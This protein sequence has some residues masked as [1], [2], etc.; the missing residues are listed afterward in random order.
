MS[1]PSGKAVR[2][3][4]K[5]GA[6]APK[7]GVQTPVFFVF[8][9]MLP[10][11][12]GFVLFTAYP[13]VASLYQSFTRWDMVN[14]PRWIGLD[15]YKRMFFEDDLFWLSFKN[16]IWISATSIPIRIAFAM[17]TAFLLTKAGK[18][19]NIWR[20][21]FFLPSM[22]PVVAGTLIFAW[23]FQP[24]F[25]VLNLFLEKLGIVNMKHPLM[26]FDDPNMSKWA[27]I[28]MGLWGIGDTMIIFL[29]GLL[30][31]DKSLYESASLEG[32]NGFQQF[33]FITL[34]LMTPVIFFSAVTGI[35]GSF[36]YF[37][38]AYIATGLSIN[39]DYSKSMY[40][41]A[42]HIYETAFQQYDMGYAASLS[43]FLLFVTLICTVIML[44][45]QKRWVH[46][47]NGTMFK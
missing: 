37:T 43:W 14:A 39:N 40:F 15:N 41:Y 24:Y 12:S 34:P 46:Y 6:T 9:C 10:W 2:S 5:R 17:F 25:G 45:T 21:I 22:V 7:H 4:R 23:L 11:T 27:L 1:F 18:T 47:P 36:Q 26:W 31:I 3:P 44:L 19:R 29:A 8:M 42:T 28:I 20:T 30:D 33:R 35:I 16:T 13:M 38:Q 32:A